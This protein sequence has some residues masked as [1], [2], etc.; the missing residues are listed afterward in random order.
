MNRNMR[1]R[2]SVIL[3]LFVEGRQILKHVQFSEAIRNSKF[4]MVPA[5]VT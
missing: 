1:L 5:P 4:I 3:P 2:V